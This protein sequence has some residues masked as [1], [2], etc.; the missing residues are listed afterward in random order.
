MYDSTGFLTKSKTFKTFSIPPLRTS[1]TMETLG[2]FQKHEF[3]QIPTLETMKMMMIMLYILFTLLCWSWI[4]VEKSVA[5]TTETGLSLVVVVLGC[6]GK[7]GN[8]VDS[9]LNMIT[10]R[11]QPGQVVVESG[12]DGANCVF[13]ERWREE[14]QNS[15]RRR[16]RVAEKTASDPTQIPACFT[17][18]SP[19]P[20][21]SLLILFL[22]P[23]IFQICAFSFSLRLSFLQYILW[24]QQVFFLQ[25]PFRQPLCPLTSY[26]SSTELFACRLHYRSFPHFFSLLHLSVFILRFPI[27]WTSSCFMTESDE[28][29]VLRDCFITR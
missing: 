19:L 1:L 5:A 23:R 18:T 2:K 27:K 25:N 9:S 16:V 13:S 22:F 21:L 4:E 10:W 29:N 7:S 17:P 24:L 6:W 15:R 8:D 12:L 3:S 14:T 28:A 26:L 20:Y 11:R